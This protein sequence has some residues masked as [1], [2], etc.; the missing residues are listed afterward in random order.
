[1]YIYMFINPG[2][3]EADKNLRLRQHLTTYVSRCASWKPTAQPLASP[4][5]T[6]P[7]KPASNT[8][9]DD[10]D[11]RSDLRSGASG[12]ATDDDVPRAPPP[13]VRRF[14]R[15]HLVQRATRPSLRVAAENVAGEWIRVPSRFIVAATA[16][17][18]SRSRWSDLFSE[19][20]FDGNFDSKQV[21]LKVEPARSRRTE[22]KLRKQ[23]KLPATQKLRRVPYIFL[24][25]EQKMRS[26]A[27]AV[28]LSRKEHKRW[29]VVLLNNLDT[30][31][32]RN[33][34]HTWLWKKI[35]VY[36]FDQQLVKL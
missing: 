30:S 11:A 35:N 31:P 8:T 21:F 16:A 33:I 12:R 14:C 32:S 9:T 22:T 17:S 18:A 26:V 6:T 23:I 36:N 7:T 10:A 2:T 19:G 4:S 5:S 28:D 29:L 13:V 25:R 27:G 1:M 3:D 24:D 34:D 15:S 20:Y